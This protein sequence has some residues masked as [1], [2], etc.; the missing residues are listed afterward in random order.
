MSGWLAS[1]CSPPSSPEIQLPA[2][3]DDPVERTGVARVAG[4]PLAM[5]ERD[6][7]AP[8]A[9]F[10]AHIELLLDRAGSARLGLRIAGVLAFGDAFLQ[11]FLECHARSA[12]PGRFCLD[13]ES[14]MRNLDAGKEARRMPA[15]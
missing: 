10:L 14:S 8:Q 11:S 12:P 4:R 15:I 7:I 13:Q 5:A 1:S 6:V 9:A 3:I 2:P